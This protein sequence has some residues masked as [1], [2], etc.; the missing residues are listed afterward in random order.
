MDLLFSLSP[1]TTISGF[2]ILKIFMV[3]YFLPPLHSFPSLNL[4]LKFFII[5]GVR[6]TPNRSLTAVHKL[7]PG[8]IYV[9]VVPPLFI[10]HPSL[11]LRSVMMKLDR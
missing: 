2:S 5:P 7:V 10:P 3:I 9:N 6:T 1:N 11:F 4:F 8:I